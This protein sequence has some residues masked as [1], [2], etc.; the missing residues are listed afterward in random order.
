VEQLVQLLP[1]VAIVLVFW[2]LV[3]RPASRRQKALREL[4]NA[5][6]VDDRVMLSSGIH[7]TVRGIGDERVEVEI[8]DGVV[9]SVARG[10]IATR[11]DRLEQGR[12]G[13]VPPTTEGDGNL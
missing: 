7:G 6:Q 12:P 13:D 1:L 4:Q 10:A 8:A 5:L 11:Q 9:V 2:L 3:L